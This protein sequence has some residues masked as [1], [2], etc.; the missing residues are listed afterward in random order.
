M[1]TKDYLAQDKET[2]LKKLEA[3][4]DTEMS[5]RAAEEEMNRI[6]TRCA[7]ENLAPV[8][9]MAVQNT[10]QTA[11]A[12][13]SLMDTAG[14]VRIYERKGS[15]EKLLSEAAIRALV[16]SGMVWLLG[17]VLLSRG[18]AGSILLGLLLS[19][20]GYAWAF[21]TGRKAGQD[22]Q[23]SEPPIIRTTTDPQK[24]YHQMDMLLTVV[25]QRIQD[26]ID[27]EN[28]RISRSL[29]EDA[30]SGQMEE[31]LKLF[32]DL[33]ALA[34]MQRDEVYA[35]EMISD[36]RFYLHRQQVDV[37]DYDEKVA[38]LFDMIPS[39]GSGTIRP[40]LVQDGTVLC[41]GIAAVE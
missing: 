27:M 12:A 1:N 4:T 19:A 37:V 2:L 5:I 24:V 10:L 28:T 6:L 39:G 9:A 18:G 17:A 8:A 14:E 36:I 25:D 22:R 13:L 16:P 30:A 11:K 20:G 34:Y 29:K 31:E 15:E 32:S 7:Q 40:A 21:L 33:L 35:R 41:K 38:R 3:S 23:E 26:T